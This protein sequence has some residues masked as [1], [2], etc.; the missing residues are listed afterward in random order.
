M[1]CVIERCLRR[2]WKVGMGW[3][4]GLSRSRDS[5]AVV[6]GG[7]EGTEPGRVPGGNEGN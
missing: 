7:A 4:V 5:A 1:V 3:R 6:T 2:W